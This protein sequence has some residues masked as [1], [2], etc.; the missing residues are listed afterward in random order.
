MGTAWGHL[1]LPPENG[2][3]ATSLLIDLIEQI[4]A[5]ISWESPN[6]Q[7]QL[8]TKGILA[9]YVINSLTSGRITKY[10]VMMLTY[11]LAS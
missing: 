3:N 4:I 1:P 6:H 10:Q 5:G 2:R 7:L 9:G 11:F 8:G